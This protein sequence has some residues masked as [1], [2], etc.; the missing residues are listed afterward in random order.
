[1]EKQRRPRD[2]CEIK[3]FINILYLYIY[4]CWNLF[5]LVVE[6]VFQT[7]PETFTSNHLS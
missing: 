5:I 2:E 3:V 4:I 7:G 6:S 1:M